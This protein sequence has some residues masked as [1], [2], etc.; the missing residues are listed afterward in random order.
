MVTLKYFNK[1]VKKFVKNYIFCYLIHKICYKKFCLKKLLKVRSM[2]SP[3]WKKTATYVGFQSNRIKRGNTLFLIKIL[4]Y[5]VV[6]FNNL[7]FSVK[8]FSI[9]FEGF[10]ASK[11]YKKVN[12]CILLKFL[13]FFYFV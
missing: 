13:Q 4:K 1:I 5:G 10:F 11:A 3:L 12:P 9:Y 2:L 6:I 8:Y 7:T